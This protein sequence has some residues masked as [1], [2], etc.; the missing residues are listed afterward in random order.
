MEYPT[1]QK[2][3]DEE[4]N[5]EQLTTS[6]DGLTSEVIT[7]YQTCLGAQIL[8][9]STCETIRSLSNHSIEY[10]EL[11]KDEVTELAAF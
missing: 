2:D 7:I 1:I 3:I 11:R 10:P 9:C 6:Q 5:S 8:I 4:T